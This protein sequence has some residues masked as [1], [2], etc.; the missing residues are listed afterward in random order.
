MSAKLMVLGT[1][2]RHG[3]AYGYKVYQEIRS[4][5]AES[6]SKVRP[7][8]IYHA[9]SQLDKEG[10]IQNTGTA[11]QHGPAR[12][13]YS[14]TDLGKQELLRLVKKSLVEYDPELFAAG[15]AFMHLLPRQTVIGLAHERLDAHMDVV[16]FLN[17]LPQEQLPSTPDKHP[18]IVGTWEHYFSSTTAWQ[19]G[20]IERLQ[21]GRYVFGDETETNAYVEGAR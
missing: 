13:N 6:W 7:G 11:K 3:E 8:S 14:I 12:T 20:F 15:L 10:F 4:W 19:K 5:Q 21:E 16:S 2:N 9:L 1:I 17:T 18:E